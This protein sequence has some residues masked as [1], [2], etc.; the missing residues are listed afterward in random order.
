MVSSTELPPFAGKATKRLSLLSLRKGIQLYLELEKSEKS[1]MPAQNHIPPELYTAEEMEQIL[2]KW[3][4]D[5]EG[6]S[7]IRSA[8]IRCAWIIFCVLKWS[9]EMVCT[10]QEPKSSLLRLV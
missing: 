5:C 2:Q 4:Q 3:E 1:Q 9:H 10:W 7:V 8:V 6:E